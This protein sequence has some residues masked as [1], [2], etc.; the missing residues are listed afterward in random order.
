MTVEDLL[1]EYAWIIQKF[2]E[3]DGMTFDELNHEWVKD[4]EFSGGVEMAYHNFRR[5]RKDIDKALGLV[6]SYDHKR[7]VY[8]LE[9]K[10]PKKGNELLEWIFQMSMVNKALKGLMGMERRVSL[11]RF[12]M[13]EHVIEKVTDAIK[14]NKELEIYY[15][16]Q[17]SDQVKMHIVEPYGL[18]MYDSRTY[19]IAKRKDKLIP[20][21][22]DRIKSLKATGRNFILPDDFDIHEYFFHYFGVFRDESIPPEEIVIWT[23]S[24]EHRYLDELP[25]HHSQQR[26]DIEDCDHREYKLFLSPTNDF[27]GKILYKADRIKV[28]RPKWVAEKI[29][30]RLGEMQKNY[31]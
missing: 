15:L 14:Q 21:E 16:A 5:H 25:L 4:E 13:G 20:F 2:T 19:M 12:S 22:L 31:K 28:I 1:L 11:Q 27:I 23:F 7:K 30:T 6:I 9:N 10:K 8:Y 24:N 29:K 3:S 26:I 17:E 18:K